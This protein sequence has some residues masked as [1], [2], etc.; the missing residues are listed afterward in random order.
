M[1][2]RLDIPMVCGWLLLLAASST[3]TAAPSQHAIE[4]TIDAYNHLTM[5]FALLR[6]G[7]GP[8]AIR[9]DILGNVDHARLSKPVHVL[10][11]ELLTLT[12]QVLVQQ[13]DRASAAVRE[14]QRQRQQH[15]QTG[16]LL[17]VVAALVFPGSPLLPLVT[18]VSELGEPESSD[19]AVRQPGI[20]PTPA[21]LA[22][23]ISQF[24][25]DVSLARRHLISQH[26]LHERQLI[27]PADLD[28]YL[29]SRALTDDAARYRALVALH[30]RAPALYLVAYDLG[31]I[32]LEQHQFDPAAQYFTS[33][34][35]NVPDLLKRHPVRVHAQVLLGHLLT[36]RH[37]FDEALKRYDQA[38]H[39]DPGHTGALHG[40]TDALHRL[41][42]YEEAQPLYEQWL[43]LEPEHP[44]ALYNYACLLA[45]LDAGS[46]L[47]LDHLERALHAGFTD[48]A[49][50]KA[51]SEL[52]SVRALPGFAALV[53]SRIGYAVNW[54]ALI[55][56]ELYVTNQSDFHW[57]DVEIHV[58][59]RNH[60]GGW[61]SIPGQPIRKA[62]LKRGETVS[63][64]AFDATQFSLDRVRLRVQSAQDDFSVVLR[65]DRG[66]LQVVQ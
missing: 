18:M 57:T 10:Y 59:F 26:R 27:T 52:A 7:V 63:F 65:Q 15:Q 56:D 8:E 14:H 46:G 31:L 62:T 33:A 6:K 17:S 49:H 20:A 11:R 43:R 47:V 39:E 44:G 55:P 37:A 34:L 3:A 60:Q 42:R 24:E 2:F 13:H 35:E 53:Q 48:I 45:Q 41:A 51:D 22:D 16:E 29:Q 66:A 50:A 38:L 5:S 36:R 19:L 40:K 23:R 54:N 12:D 58:V 21:V 4:T 30:Q 28:A 9:Q 64:A 1:R 32:T 61:Q 25:F